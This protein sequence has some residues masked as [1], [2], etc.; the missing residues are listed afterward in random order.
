MYD[1]ITHV[2]L[3][4]N[5]RLAFQ[6]IEQ[7]RKLL[8][9]NKSLIL[10]EDFGA[11]SVVLKKKKRRIDQIAASS[12]KSKKYA[13]LLY[14]IAEYYQPESVIE[15]GTSFGITTAY[16]AKSHEK[17][18]IITFE[19]A[20]EVAAMAQKTFSD[21]QI[22]NIEL[23]VGDFNLRLPEYL[24]SKPKINLAFMDGNHRRQPTLHYFNQIIQHTHSSSIL[25][26]DDIHWSAEMEAAWEE[27]KNHPSVTLS[28]DLF[29]IG[30]V[31]FRK[32]FK[33][34]QHFTI[35]F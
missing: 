23:Y 32:D 33:V 10:V 34:K 22:S 35:Q 24:E 3:D 6:E 26:F 27:I 12:L 4:K 1:F 31:F 17:I 15:L 11:G 29:F 25:I 14:R 2:L 9:K 28:I 20:P 19:G 18:Q 21:L 16:L 5:E 13:Q 30:L 7:H 8:L